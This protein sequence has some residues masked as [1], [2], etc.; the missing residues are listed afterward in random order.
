MGILRSNGTS[1]GVNVS[2]KKRL[3]NIIN[4]D[5]GKVNK[6]T[7]KNIAGTWMMNATAK[8]IFSH[9]RTEFA[10]YIL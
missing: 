5:I 10:G 7:N 2:E 6:H 4:G 8:F 3:G 1:K 9:R